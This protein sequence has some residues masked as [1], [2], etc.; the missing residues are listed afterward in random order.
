VVTTGGTAGL[1]ELCTHT[2]THTHTHIHTTKKNVYTATA[3]PH[4]AQ[5]MKFSGY[6]QMQA[7]SRVKVFGHAVTMTGCTPREIDQPTNQA[8]C[9]NQ[10]TN[11]V[12]E[13]PART[14]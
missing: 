14:H 3:T 12:W 8:A 5:R 2:H 10:P 9:L 13:N 6:A 1:R 11:F 7:R 4:S